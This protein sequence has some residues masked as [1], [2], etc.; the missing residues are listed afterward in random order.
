MTLPVSRRDQSYAT[1]WA[2]CFSVTISCSGLGIF[3]NE[4]LVQKSV[5]FTNHE[6]TIFQSLDGS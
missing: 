5:C 1:G 3:L 4:N 2:S 6:L